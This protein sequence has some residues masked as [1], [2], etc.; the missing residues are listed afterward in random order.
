MVSSKPSWLWGAGILASVGTKHSNTDAV[1]FESAASI[2]KRTL[3][4]P[5][6]MVSLPIAGPYRGIRS[7]GK[8]IKTG[9]SAQCWHADAKGALTTKILARAEK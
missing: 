2:K 6:V 1:P 3:S 9:R 4:A 7:S 8:L 5:T